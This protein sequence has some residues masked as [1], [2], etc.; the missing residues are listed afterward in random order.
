MPNYIPIG[1][2]EKKFVEGGIRKWQH[3]NKVQVRLRTVSRNPKRV[4]AVTNLHPSKE[5]AAPAKR[6]SLHKKENSAP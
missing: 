1:S 5:K 2:A 6:L 3:K 4:I